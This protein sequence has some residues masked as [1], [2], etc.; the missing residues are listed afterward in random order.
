LTTDNKDFK[1]KNGLIVEGATA[2]VNGNNVLTEASSIGDLSDVN[3]SGVSN[4]EVLTY[5]SGNW[6]PSTV[7]GGGGGGGQIISDSVPLIASAGD[8]WFDSTTGI[9]YIYYDDGDSSQWVQFGIGRE[10]PIG[11]Q[12]PTGPQGVTGPTGPTG[13]QGEDGGWSIPYTINNQSSSYI[14]VLSDAGKFIE[15]NNA[16]A[17]TLTI[18]ADS[19]VN[20]DVGTNITILQS[21]A[22][23]VTLTPVSVEV[24]LDGTPGLKLREQWSS[25]TIVKRAANTWVAIGDLMP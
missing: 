9:S 6:V 11:P 7:S 2:T 20:F 24:T 8:V 23:Q 18:P 12:G 25:A 10:G 5:S 19:S 21:G 16:G 1:I 3:L 4:G 15:I 14:I 17:T 22:G 13:P